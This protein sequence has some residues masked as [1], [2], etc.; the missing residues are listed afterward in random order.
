MVVEI[1][2]LSTGNLVAKVEAKDF[3]ALIA[4]NFHA[5]RNIWL[6]EAIMIYNKNYPENTARWKLK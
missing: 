3:I 6:A 4:D 1:I 2:E 5:P